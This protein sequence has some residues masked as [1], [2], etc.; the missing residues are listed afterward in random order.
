MIS[1][2]TIQPGDQSMYYLNQIFGTVGNIFGNLS[3]DGSVTAPSQILGTLFQVLNTSILVLGT[4]L[5]VYITI[6]G[7]LNT[8]H[9][10]ELFGKK[11][12]PIWM[13]IRMVLGIVM[14]F[15][16]AG[17]YSILQILIMWFITQGVGLAD[18]TWGVALSYAQTAGSPFSGTSF[19]KPDGISLP[20]KLQPLFASLVCQATARQ[21]DTSNPQL[22]TYADGKTTPLYYCNANPNDDL[23]KQSDTEI[24]NIK[25][26]PHVTT[27]TVPATT[28]SPALTK[29]TYNMGPTGNTCGTLSYDIPP[30]SCSYDPNG[31][32]S[33][34]INCLAQTAQPDVLQGIVLALGTIANKVA[35]TD[36]SY[37]QWHDS[38]PIASKVQPPSWI[39][40]YCQANGVSSNQ[41]C[42]N[43]MN[44][45][46][47]PQ[48]LA[49]GGS[50]LF[51]PYSDTSSTDFN[52]PQNTVKNIY[53]PYAISH[54]LGDTSDFI[55]I[56][57]NQW[58]MG[59]IINSQTQFIATQGT[60]VLTGWYSDANKA[61]WILAG[62]YFYNLAQ[63]QATTNTITTTFDVTIGTNGTPPTGFRNNITTASYL[64]S[65]ISAATQ[66]TNGGSQVPQSYG[67]LGDIQD[68]AKAA[69]LRGIKNQLT[70][71]GDSGGIGN[72]NPLGKLA[73]YGQFLM[74]MAEGIFGALIYTIPGVMALLTFDPIVLGNGVT[75]NPIGEGFK[76]FISILS[77]FVVLL[78]STMFSLGALLGIYTPFIPYIVFTMA[79]IGWMIGVIEA[80]TAA[81]FIALGILSPAGQ[82]ELLGR[83]EPAV[84]ML[85][86]IFVRPTLMVI[87]LIVS[88]LFAV[89]VIKFINVAFMATV[90]SIMDFNSIG[91]FEQIILI[92]VYTTVI[93]SALNKCFSLIHYL[94]EQALTWIGGHAK[95]FGEGEA[96]REVKSGAEA[97]GGA[98]VRGGQESGTA[99]KAGGEKVGGEAA[100][101]KKAPAGGPG[102]GGSS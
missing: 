87:G 91:L 36:S 5:V 45:T 12:S 24:L 10:G 48:T 21:K 83:A 67:A 61:G 53:F 33:V 98:A 62:R 4:L 89:V 82:H 25:N 96:L 3:S 81:P 23:C 85:F 31:N 101:G 93:L 74:R 38:T 58:L 34:Y 41:C 30:A 26:G 49:C 63:L 71:S 8:A 1:L 72:T 15:P 95:S 84:M 94:P 66:T 102:V 42:R 17:G 80:M 97:A 100:K 90:S 2:F 56:A 54:Y 73:S 18:K 19:N 40:T 59:V 28:T 27:S 78:I 46:P 92:A 50:G 69:L 55:T 88:M 43:S 44:P 77:P 29:I 68:S 7:V 57:A 22:T 9:E 60:S 99:A 16:A 32:P 47:P 65:A 20:S 64:L 70:E 79:A 52:A 51:L 39:N 6:V 13:P 37:S 14:M 35:E 86:T 75:T 76:S 11:F